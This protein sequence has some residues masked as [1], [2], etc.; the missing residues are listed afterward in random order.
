MS[1]YIY[2]KLHCICQK[3]I[4]FFERNTNAILCPSEDKALHVLLNSIEFVGARLDKST[5]FIAGVAEEV[6]ANSLTLLASKSSCMPLKWRIYCIKRVE[7]LIGIL[8]WICKTHTPYYILFRMTSRSSPPLV[9]IPCGL[10]GG[11]RWET[12]RRWFICEFDTL[13][14]IKK[15]LLRS[16]YGRD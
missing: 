13:W 6:A 4:N 7:S 11:H 10:C 12:G 2:W 8:L 16:H 9:I 1:L 15:K 14:K 3:T 5:C